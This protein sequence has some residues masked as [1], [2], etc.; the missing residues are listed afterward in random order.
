MRYSAVPRRSFLARPR[1]LIS[2]VSRPDLID[3]L[4]GAPI[5]MCIHPPSSLRQRRRPAH[6]IR[7]LGY[8]FFSFILF[9]FTHDSPQSPER[10]SI[11]RSFE[12]DLFCRCLQVP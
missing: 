9:Y 2:F 1:P 8:D 5:T 4:L 12:I 6:C 10:S 7:V 11:A 3:A